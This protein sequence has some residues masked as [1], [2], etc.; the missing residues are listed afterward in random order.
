MPKKALKVPR[1]DYL[2]IGDSEVAVGKKKA[3]KGLI[4]FLRIILRSSAMVA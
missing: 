2:G 1:S 4:Y 3:P